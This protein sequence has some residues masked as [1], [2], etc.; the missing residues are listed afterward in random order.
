ML[1]FL[2]LVF[3][4]AIVNQLETDVITAQQAILYSTYG[5]IM[6][7][8]TS[9]PYWNEELK[10]NGKKKRTNSHNHTRN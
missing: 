3:V 2:S 8:H 1:A 7:Y 9:K 5:L 4:F 6:F 10:K